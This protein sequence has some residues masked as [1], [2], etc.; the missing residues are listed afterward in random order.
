M[1]TLVATP[2]VVVLACLFVLIRTALGQ[3]D[4]YCDGPFPGCPDTACV[5]DSGT[6]PDG[7]N[8]AGQQYSAGSHATLEVTSCAPGSGS[9]MT[10][11]KSYCAILCYESAGTNGVCLNFMC[12]DSQTVDQCNQ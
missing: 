3:S 6:C 11:A 2:A 5:D 10:S 9:C 12:D 7:G 4:F 8:D 1:K